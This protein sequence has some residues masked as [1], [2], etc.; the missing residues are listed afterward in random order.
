MTTA[1]NQMPVWFALDLG[2]LLRPKRVIATADLA[3]SGE[4]PVAR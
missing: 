1:R 2:E 3:G 4:V